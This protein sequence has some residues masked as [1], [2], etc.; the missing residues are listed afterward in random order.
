VT[1]PVYFTAP[2]GI[3][4]RVLDSAW[5]KGKRLLANPPAAWATTRIFRP[6]EGRW[7][8]YPLGYLELHPEWTLEPTP[9]M[10]AILFARSEPGGNAN[11]LTLAARAARASPA[12]ESAAPRGGRTPGTWIRKFQSSTAQGVHGT[13]H[14][15][16]AHSEDETHALFAR[17]EG[18]ERVRVCFAWLPVW[19]DGSWCP[20]WWR[21]FVVSE[22]LD[23]DY[24]G[25]STGIWVV[26]SRVPLEALDR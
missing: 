2:D 22:R 25:W 7:R 23:A 17:G 8:F 21:H 18:A 14:A 24:S 10:L 16:S 11:D 4:Y 6:R 13:L 1:E 20:I 5:R 19:C 12:S 26:T 9:E 15:M 3:T